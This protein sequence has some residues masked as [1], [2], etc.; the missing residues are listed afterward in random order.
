[1]RALRAC[2]V[3]A[4]ASLV[5]DEL[6]SGRRLAPESWAHSSNGPSRQASAALRPSSCEMRPN[7]RTAHD[8]RVGELQWPPED[9]EN[10]TNRTVNAL[11]TG[12]NAEIGNAAVRARKPWSHA[13]SSARAHRRTSFVYDLASRGRTTTRLPPETCS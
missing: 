7:S 11:K 12:Q 13:A 6:L 3:V 8:F 2:A 4:D 10:V 1:M 9:G 5:V